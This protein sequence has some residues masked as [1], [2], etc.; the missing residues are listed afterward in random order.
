MLFADDAALVAHTEKA[1]HRLGDS[2]KA[3]TEV[4]KVVKGRLLATDIKKLSPAEQT[5]G[6]GSFHGAICFFAPKSCPDGSKAL[7]RHIAF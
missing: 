5:S 4:E 3:H 6:L 1:L 7:S 2:S